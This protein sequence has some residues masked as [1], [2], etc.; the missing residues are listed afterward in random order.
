MRSSLRIHVPNK[1]WITLD[2]VFPV[3]I[4]LSACIAIGLS[5]TP[6]LP[7]SPADQ[8][9]IALLTLLAIDSFKERLGVLQRIYAMLTCLLS[10]RTRLGGR[11]EMVSVEE[12]AIGASQIYIIGISCISLIPPHRAFF[13]ERLANGCEI[14][15]ILLDPHAQSCMSLLQKIRK[16]DY[17][18]DIE[19]MIKHLEMLSQKRKTPEALKWRFSDVFIP[20]SMFAVDLE[21]ESGSIIIEYLCF[22]TDWTDRPHVYL[23]KKENPEWFHF[24]VDQFKGIWAQSREK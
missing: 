13:S 14:R 2:R 8:I 9:I 3:V 1:L 17:A 19:V 21:K 5:F 16:W 15:I 10:H 4:I 22:D 18:K 6:F 23:T 12:Q 24:Y 7:L 11:S 20:F